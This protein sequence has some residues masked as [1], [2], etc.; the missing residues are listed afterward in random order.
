MKH[1]TKHGRMYRPTDGPSLRRLSQR[2]T[3][4]FRPSFDWRPSSLQV[5]IPVGLDFGYCQAD[6]VSERVFFVQNTGEVKIASKSF[7]CTPGH[8]KSS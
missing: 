5:G 8:C 1:H 6:D 3:S 2:V 4:H 7:V